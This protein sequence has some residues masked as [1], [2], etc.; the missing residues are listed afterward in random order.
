MF[1]T[2]ENST[3]LCT[4]Y[5]G[6]LLHVAKSVISYSPFTR[7]NFVHTGE[8]FEESHDHALFGHNDRIIKESA[9]VEHCKSACLA[10]ESFYCKSFDLVSSSGTC[11]LSSDDQDSAPEMYG[12][13]HGST[14]YER[15]TC[16]VEVTESPP[17]EGGKLGLCILYHICS[18][19]VFPF[20]YS[21]LCHTT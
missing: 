10:E 11:Y 21:F 13:H 4:S 15:K 6:A 18:Y 17:V 19:F 20:L 2:T 9:D 3:V 14:Y 16:V 7:L 5:F 12:P 1:V 8:Y